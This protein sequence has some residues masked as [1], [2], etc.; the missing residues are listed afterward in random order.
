[1]T[2][3][4]KK[5]ETVL[6][7]SAPRR[8]DH[9]IKTVAGSENVWSL[10]QEGWACIADDDGNEG[11]PLWPEPEYAEPY[12]DKVFPSWEVRSICV[13]RL[14]DEILPNIRDQGNYIA[15]F[16]TENGSIW[17]ELSRIEVDLRH[18]LSRYE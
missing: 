16:P 5:L 1:M 3:D 7:L 15:V 18:E 8:Y 11:L 4:P 12:R 2:V 13:Q 14:L 17:P 9:F 10:W 6:K